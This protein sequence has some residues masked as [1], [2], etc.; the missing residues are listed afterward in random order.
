[1]AYLS[2]L[3]RRAA[4]ANPVQW[5][6]VQLAHDNWSY[7]SQGLTPARAALLSIAVAACTGGNNYLPKMEID[8]QTYAVHADGK[9]LTR[10]TATSLPMTQRYFLF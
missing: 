9:L 6:Q 2:Q 8:A 1:M 10:E 7:K 3:S 4:Q 5:S